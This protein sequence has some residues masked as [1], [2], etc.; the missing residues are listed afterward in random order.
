MAS[1]HIYPWAV[2]LYLEPVS[3]WLIF[4]IRWT[5]KSSYHLEKEGKKS[6]RVPRW[7][8][9]IP[10]ITC[11]ISNQVLLSCRPQFPR[12]TAKPKCSISRTASLETTTTYTTK[13]LWVFFFTG[14]TRE[15]ERDGCLTFHHPSSPQLSPSLLKPKW[16]KSKNRVLQKKRRYVFI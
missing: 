6:R 9:D 16:K 10:L 15:R 4:Q 12:H 8:R 14:R 3:G 1:F 11:I 2:S 7:N 13:R 5:E